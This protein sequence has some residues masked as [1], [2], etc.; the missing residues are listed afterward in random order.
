MGSTSHPGSPWRHLPA[1]MPPPTP[2]WG[3]LL[4]S[5]LPHG[6][7]VMVGAGVGRGPC[8]QLSSHLPSAALRPKSCGDELLFADEGTEHRDLRLQGPQL[9]AIPVPP[10][11]LGGQ[12]D[13]G[14]RG[15]GTAGEVTGR[16]SDLHILEAEPHQGPAADNTED[17][18][19][20]LI[21]LTPSP[22]EPGSASEPASTRP[23]SSPSLLAGLWAQ[24]AALPPGSQPQDK[25]EEGRG[26]PWRS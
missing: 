11:P 7:A 24:G 23:S 26:R 2:A 12:W 15:L 18:Q 4:P 10:S 20:S 14:S 8:A 17:P 3:A 6:R 1:P 5:L 19:T 22:V 21:D 16:V 25:G 13:L 9:P